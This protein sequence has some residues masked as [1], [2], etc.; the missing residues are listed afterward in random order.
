MSLERYIPLPKSLGFFNE[1]G[2]EFNFSATIHTS[3]ASISVG[4][5]GGEYQLSTPSI[6]HLLYGA[7]LISILSFVIIVVLYMSFGYRGAM[8]QIVFGPG[9]KYEDVREIHYTYSGIKA[10]LRKY[11]VK[12][13]EEMRCPSCTP[14]EVATK[15]NKYT[16]FAEIYEDVVYGCKERTDVQDILGGVEDE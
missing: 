4:V 11:Y 9:K 14:R 13:R 7:L 8:V 6:V 1:N 3:N 5:S 2:T 15:I 16:M 12:I 10:I